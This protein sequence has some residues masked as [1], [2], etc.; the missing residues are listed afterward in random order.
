MRSVLALLAVTA[1]AAQSTANR[2]QWDLRLNETRGPIRSADVSPLAKGALSEILGGPTNGSDNAYLLYTRMAPGATE[3]TVRNQYLKSGQPPVPVDYAMK[4]TPAGWMIYDIT[5]DG[6][7]L[8]LTYR[9]EFETITKTA[10]VGGLIKRMHE[11][12]A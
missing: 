4:K 10:G 9:S 3:V 11:K 6:V 2:P 1:M 8:V 5:V 12:N 7:S